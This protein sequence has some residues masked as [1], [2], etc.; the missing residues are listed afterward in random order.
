M[1]SDNGRLQELLERYLSKFEAMVDLAHQQQ[2]RETCRRVFELEPVPELPFVL[3]DVSG[4]PDR[5]WPTFPYNDTFFD[6]A[7]MLLNE[8]W[9]PFMHN[10]LRDFHPLNIR[11]NYG[12]PILPSV[13][14][15]RFRLMETS[16]PW[17]HPLGGREEIRRLIARGV[18]DCETGLG[19][20]CFETA[21]FYQETLAGY[22]RLQRA[23][24]I[25]HPDLQGPFDVAHLIW[26]PD[27]FLGIY[28][29]PDLVHALLA[30]VTE[31]YSIWMKKWKRLVGEGNDFTT[32][33]SFYIKGGVVLR[34]DTPVML[35]AAHF[36]EFV[37]PYDQLLLDEF[38]GGV[39]FCG[40]G[41]QFVASLCQMR[42]LSCVHSSQPEL[43]DVGLLIDSAVSNRVV[44]LGLPEKYVPHDL[45]TGVIV[46]K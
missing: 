8:L 32:Q 18:P 20:R 29:C 14:G 21:R 35:S 22:P 6:P 31:T 7:K 2:A 38:G 25:Y 16:K 3:G 44:L 36:D 11:A 13:F 33:W 45:E 19:G 24:S 17:S 42:N 5:D 12:T 39:H 1:T 9:A 34:D 15:A 10:Q 30:L 4:A 43:N 23:L 37:K 26:G 40:K 41:D 27:I 46:L 28:D